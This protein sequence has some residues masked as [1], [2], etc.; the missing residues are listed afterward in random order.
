M[1]NTNLANAKRDF[2]ELVD[3]ILKF[4]ETVTVVCQ[5]GNLVMLKEETYRNIVES[6]YLIT[7]KDIKEDI[8]EV[9]KTPTDELIERSPYC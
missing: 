5:K 4:D 9:I 7:S 3:S 6:L 2:S 1:I 8:E